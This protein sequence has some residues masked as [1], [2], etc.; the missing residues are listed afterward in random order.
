LE[1]LVEPPLDA[2]GFLLDVLV[3]DR[4]DLEALEIG[5]ACGG[6]ISTRAE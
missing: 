2:A 1:D 5:R 6:A 4:D 3:V